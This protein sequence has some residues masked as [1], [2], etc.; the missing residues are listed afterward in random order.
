LGIT[1]AKLL[2]QWLNKG[3]K[4]IEYNTATIEADEKTSEDDPPSIKDFFDHRRYK[5]PLK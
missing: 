1:P 5:I 2:Y 4:P 3:S